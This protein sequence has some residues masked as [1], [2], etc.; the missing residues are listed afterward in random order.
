MSEGEA[1]KSK[2]LKFTQKY[3]KN[4]DL[5][6]RNKKMLNKIRELYKT[7]HYTQCELGKIF[8]IS[9]TGISMIIN[10]QGIYKD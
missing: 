2:F 4:K 6:V 3:R 7:Y 10:Y 8:G 9:Q 1:I 5:V